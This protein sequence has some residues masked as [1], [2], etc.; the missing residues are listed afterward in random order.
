MAKFL[1][2]NKN[3]KLY[4]K[5]TKK[6]R[7]RMKKKI[8][9][10]VLALMML[11]SFGLTACGG[12]GGEDGTYDIEIRAFLNNGHYFD[13]AEKNS[14]WK[15]LEKAAGA[16]IKIEGASRG[17]YDTTLFPMVNTLDVPDLLFT[18]G[19]D[20]FQLWADP[21]DGILWNFDD[22][23]AMYPGEFPYLEEIVYS[24]QYVNATTLGQHVLLPNPSYASGWG[25][26]Y[27]A[28]WLKAVGF[29]ND[30]GSPK[31]PTN[32]DEF[33]EVMKLFTHNDP[34]GNGKN[35]TFA[36]SPGGQPH[37]FNIFMSAFGFNSD[38]VLEG[39]E[40][41][42]GLVREE[43]KDLLTWL[44]KCFN[45]GLID[46]AFNTNS[47]NA[48]REKFESSKMGIIITNAEPH[49]QWVAKPVMKLF[50]DDSVIMGPAPKGTA[51]IGKEGSGGFTNWGGSW[52]GFCIGNHVKGDKL[53]A[54]LKLLEYCYSPEG[55]M[56]KS[57]G[58]QGV[59]YESFSPETGI[60]ITEENIQNRLAEPSNTF[61]MVEQADGTSLP[62]GMSQHQ[63][64]FAAGPIDWEATRKA[65][66]VILLSDYIGLYGEALGKL[67]AA[68]N[69]YMYYMP[70]NLVNITSYPTAMNAKKNKVEDLAKAYFI[71]AILG[72]ANLT[73]DWD[74]FQTD[75]LDAGWE[76]VQ[77]LML[78]TV[79]SLGVE[80]L[81]QE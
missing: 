3:I 46:P 68:A 33:Y 40:I 56:V 72:Q 54:V 80:D 10:L 29:T 34:D 70:G 48:D 26:Y 24:E 45:E 7:I 19:G 36:L 75:I 15:E 81:I 69:D 5:K 20:A 59:H 50:G 21:D 65:G 41:R 51:T 77:S 13:G 78:E 14:I 43:M 74:Q 62:L 27:R 60:V 4:L 53:K 18:T 42:Y 66:A 8:L 1:Y 64:M 58:I 67:A 44:N 37:F 57:F 55:S 6:G 76:D 61:T 28:D 49:V 23:F 16:N 2:Y 52:G 12:G 39:G 22:L 30:D 9:V 31:V 17:D 38:Y 63:Q 79:L 25:V 35:D 32:M 71:K 11:C 47:N 73:S